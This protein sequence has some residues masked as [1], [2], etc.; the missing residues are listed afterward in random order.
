MS[1]KLDILNALKSAAIAPQAMPVIDIAPR[2]DDLVGQFET[3]LNTV[4]GTLHREGG[5]AK[6]QTQVDEHIAQGMQIIS[7]VDGIIGNREVTDTAHQLRDID[8]AVI[9]GDL[10]VAEN[11][12]IWVNN[13][14]LGHRVTPFICENLF[15]VLEANTIVANMHQAAS[16]ITLDSGEFGT[17]IA[18]P[19]KTADIEQALVVGAHGACSL[20]V[21]LV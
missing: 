7:M 5:L 15:L 19:S 11:G 3:S 10:G 2:I 18:G 16:R 1:S 6:L 21:Y 14:N 13:K 20:N 17:F 9:P 12:A 4:A 8:Y